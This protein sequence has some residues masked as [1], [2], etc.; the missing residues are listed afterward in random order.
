LL[1]AVLE[2]RI[3]RIPNGS[4]VFVNS[5]CTSGNYLVD[6]RSSPEFSVVSGKVLFAD[7][8]PTLT[9]GIAELDRKLILRFGQLVALNG[10]DS[11]SLSSLLCVRAGLPKPDGSDSNVVFIDG[12]N[13]FDAYLLSKF[14]LK[15]KINSEKTLAKIHLSRAFN[16]HQLTRSLNEKLPLAIDE[17]KAKLAVVSDITQ[18]YCDPDIRDDREILE[19]F[20]KDIRSLVTLAEQKSIL[21]VATNLQTRN[22]RMDNILM[23]TAHVSAT[24]KDTSTFTQLNLTR[25]PFTPQLKTTISPDKQ[26]LERY[27]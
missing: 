20:T 17:L 16:Y 11:H 6:Q 2:C 26:T 15:N 3:S 9:T 4:D 14:S 19:I 27:L 10:K 23:R 7:Q 1:G 18:L 8:R 24:L 12:G 5:R 13:V 22:R 21:I 25:H